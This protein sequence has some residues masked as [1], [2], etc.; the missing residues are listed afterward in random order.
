MGPGGEGG[1]SSRPGFVLSVGACLSSPGRPL[2]WSAA[3]SVGVI[4][5]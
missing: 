2:L 3:P 5:I 1:Q 4:F